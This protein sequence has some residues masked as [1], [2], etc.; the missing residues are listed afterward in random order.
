[1]PHPELTFPEDENGDVL[2][3]MQANGDNLT[4]AR[5]I[6]FV[7]VFPSEP[8]AQEFAALYAARGHK[9]E[10][11]NSNVVPELPWDVLVV[12]HM[13]PSHLGITDFEAQL[14]EDAAALGGRNDGW[15]SFQQ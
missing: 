12:K 10:L 13:I 15:G 2:R 7:V 11:R 5:D 3:R 8:Q 4:V 1:M 9:A 14:E 6:D